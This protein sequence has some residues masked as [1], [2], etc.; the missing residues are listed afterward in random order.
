[1]A[2]IERPTPKWRWNTSRISAQAESGMGILKHA[3]RQNGAQGVTRNKAE[4][5]Q[6]IDA[7]NQ[8]GEIPSCQRLKQ[9][10][11]GE[12]PAVGG[13]GRPGK[14]NTQSSLAGSQEATDT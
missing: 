5:G 1:M 10:V 13:E 14:C 12:M 4:Q 6:S 9:G 3:G 2:T 11:R 8:R 7:T